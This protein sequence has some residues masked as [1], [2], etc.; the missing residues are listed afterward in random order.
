MS[1]RRCPSHRVAML[2]AV[3]TAALVV[4]GCGGDGSKGGGSPSTS[5]TKAGPTAS[6]SASVPAGQHNQADVAFAQG[7]IPHHRQAIVMADM[8]QEHASSSDVK[9]LA[10]KIKKAQTPEI[11]TMTTWL[12]SWGEQVPQ[13]MGGMGHGNASATPGMGMMSDHDMDQLKGATGN[14]FDTMFL[15]MMIKH[16]EGA[17]DMA[18]TEKRQGAYGPAKEMAGSIVTSQTAEIARMRKMLGTG[19]PSATATP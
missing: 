3:A 19:S 16:H 5:V 10:Q 8:A 11:E 12:K 18:N 9:A 2:A 6:A 14:A 1:I 7:M 13:G 15:T 4:T 17:V